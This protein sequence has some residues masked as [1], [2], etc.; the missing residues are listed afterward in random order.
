MRQWACRSRHGPADSETLER[1]PTRFPREKAITLAAV[2]ISDT[3]RGGFTG[4]Y[5]LFCRKIL[6]VR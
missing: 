3:A 5:P 6:Q 4:K 2:K 1:F